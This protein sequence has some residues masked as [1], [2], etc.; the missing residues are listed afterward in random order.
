MIGQRESLLTYGVICTY[1]VRSRVV[2]VLGLYKWHRT[3]DNNTDM[4]VV[5]PTTSSESGKTV[6]TDEDSGQR[7]MGGGEMGIQVNFSEC[8]EDREKLAMV[9]LQMSAA[10]M[11][12]SN[13]CA[14]YDLDRDACLRTLRLIGNLE[15]YLKQI[16][17]DE[18]ADVL[19]EERNAFEMNIV[20]SCLVEVL[21][22][23]LE[24]MMSNDCDAL[25]HAP[26]I[27]CAW[28]KLYAAFLLARS[29]EQ[30]MFSNGISNY[31][32]EEFEACSTVMH[33]A[34]DKGYVDGFLC[35]DEQHGGRDMRHIVGRCEHTDRLTDWV[36]VEYLRHVSEDEGRYL[37][38]V[39][40]DTF[41]S[42]RGIENLLLVLKLSPQLTIYT[43]D[44]VLR[45]LHAC[46]SLISESKR[47]LVCTY[48]EFVCECFEAGFRLPGFEG[49]EVAEEGHPS[50][51]MCSVLRMMYDI[52]KMFDDE[53][54]SLRARIS[55]YQKETVTRLFDS[56]NVSH[57]LSA[58]KALDS[59]VSQAISHHTFSST[60]ERHHD[61]PE[62]IAWIASTDILSSMLKAN[63]HHSQYI[64]DMQDLLRRLAIYGAVSED[65]MQYLWSIL[66]DEGTFEEIKCNVAQLL[67]SLASSMPKDNADE[68][69][70]Q[71]LADM[72]LSSSSI[73]YIGD[74]LTTASKYDAYGILIHRLMGISLNFA[75]DD[76]VPENVGS[77]G[78]FLDVCEAYEEVAGVEK[79]LAEA[80]RICMSKITIGSTED[81]TRPLQVMLHVFQGRHISRALL[82]QVYKELNPNAAFSKGLVKLYDGILENSLV[83]NKP[84]SESNREALST[85]NKVLKLVLN[86]SD[87]YVS[88]ELMKT[89]LGWTN[90]SKYSHELNEFAWNLLVSLVQGEKG[91]QSGTLHEFLLIALHK[92]QAKDLTFAAWRCITGFLAS[93]FDYSTVLY[94]GESSYT[95]LLELSKENCSMGLWDV[96]ISFLSEIVVS[97]SNEAVAREASK[98]LSSILS[99]KISVVGD[100]NS[101]NQVMESVER[102]K[103]LLHESY[104]AMFDAAIDEE[105]PWKP[106]SM[107]TFSSIDRLKII[108]QLM[109]YFKDLIRAFAPKQ[110]EDRPLDSSYK[111]D[112]VCIC[113]HFQ[114]LPLSPR[115]SANQ[116]LIEMISCPRNALV[117]DLRGMVS[118][119]ASHFVGYFIPQENFRL[120]QGVRLRLVRFVRFRSVFSVTDCFLYNTCR[121]VR[122]QIMHQAYLLAF[123]ESPL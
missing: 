10:R 37:R 6:S 118:R 75:L 89:M 48:M 122:Y 15:A 19:V 99:E 93:A 105:I 107:K 50:L 56:E 36:Q 112:D 11:N 20:H 64:E 120:F 24:R 23:V 79:V 104:Q 87:Y 52:T 96:V 95:F 8:Y 18:Y 102:C 80:I 111:G 115:A 25:I 121:V 38:A 60:N 32:Y 30:D 26:V 84:T 123:Q 55:M 61:L 77:V 71:K 14:M 43:V 90:A 1:R 12:E 28:S 58:V 34:L 109:K 91:V 2:T 73:K 81:M 78:L 31:I 116:K 98:S 54:S 33:M 106:V 88:I 4:A 110:L 51:R 66:D 82:S 94:A 119:K 70:C 22:R 3:M 29:L 114:Q 85:F 101:A 68:L 41:A 57:Q 9:L 83:G 103:G 74:L 63:L 59:I 47:M 62:H 39:V 92:I 5:I 40:L 53:G 113:A 86:D 13:Q 35:G 108:K 7:G 100:D 65:H 27:L 69:L 44:S 16:A 72:H 46:M 17:E 21:P 49:F 97:C 76:K 42:A 117:G 67:G 45:V